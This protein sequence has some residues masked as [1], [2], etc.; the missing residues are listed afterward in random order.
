LI[1]Q[2]QQWVDEPES[3]ISS[4]SQKA[5]LPPEGK[6]FRL[7]FLCNLTQGKTH[8]IKSLLK[9]FLLI[10]QEFVHSI[11][12]WLLS[13]DPG[14]LAGITHKFMG[15]IS[16]VGLENLEPTLRQL[17]QQLKSGK[18]TSQITELCR[19]LKQCCHDFEKELAEEISWL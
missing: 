10:E 17:E 19:S 6:I 18:Q 3:P 14:N 7:R 8:L 15:S 12:Q 4:A 1:T 5:L 11:D 16:L 13:K 2:L 9:D